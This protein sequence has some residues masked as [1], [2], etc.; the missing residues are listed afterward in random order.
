MIPD[1]VLEQIRSSA[2]VVAIIGEYVPLKR[3]GGSYRGACPF[4]NGKD[5]NFSVQ[6]GKGFTCFV[7]GEKG[8]VISFVQRRLGLEF[9]DAV[10]LVADKS[11]VT[12]PTEEQAGPDPRA[13]FW[14]LN[15]A[16]AHYFIDQLK[17]HTATIDYL[18]SRGLSLDDVK[19]FGLG[20]APIGNGT[21]VYL[22]ALG[23]DDR[24][25]IA[26]GLLKP[27]EDGQPARFLFRDRL[28]FPIGDAQG[29]PV[30]FG[31]RAMG[32]F[33]PKYLNSAESPVFS[34]GELLCGYFHA[35]SAARRADRLL[36]VEGFFDR[37]RLIIA[38]IE[39]VVAPLGT[40]LTEA[41]CLLV[42]KCA[43][44]VYLVYDADA[45]GL[46]ATFR[47]ADLL[48]AAGIAPK[49]VTLPAGS[50]PDSFLREH[51]RDA[52]E[53]LITSASDVLDRKLELLTAAGKLK[54]TADKRAAID[55]L[56]PTIR[57]AA[58]PLL[59]DLYL[60]RTA[61]AL[62]IRKSTLERSITGKKP[63]FGKVV[64]AE[65][66]APPRPSIATPPARPTPPWQNIPSRKA[67]P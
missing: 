36:I 28:M 41:Q 9:I 27:A 25:Q 49:I 24:R 16:A 44:D 8:D 62:G 18:T 52:L 3:A 38:G 45:A 10:R 17:S 43:S 55:K 1:H 58:D 65:F 56:M 19:R 66:T 63:R 35:K 51:G 13:P 4:H 6:P 29:H 34:K 7:C 67:A 30:G 20:Y 48:L 40:A 2:D 15:G 37:I 32:D 59:Q 61:E 46:K 26:A 21:Q 5:R 22:N 47:S 14:E 23:F 64:S 53:S 54:T 12:I 33:K 39:E 42:K 11:G 57:A 60:A 31:G 50:D